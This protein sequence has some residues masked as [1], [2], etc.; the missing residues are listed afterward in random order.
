MKKKSKLT[1][2]GPLTQHCFSTK[3]IF[4]R[5]FT[6]QQSFGALKMF[7]VFSL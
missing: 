7:Y 6:R 3:C 1:L 2:R 4:C 5:S